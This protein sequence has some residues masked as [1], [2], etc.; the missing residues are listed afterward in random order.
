VPKR[1]YQEGTFRKE[2][3]HYYS[4]FYKDRPMPDGGTRS[5]KERFHLGKVGNLSELSARR[6]HNRL[7]QQINRERGSVPPAPRGETFKDAATRYMAELAPQLSCST[8]RQKNSH[9]NCHLLPR[10]GT[11]ALMVIDHSAAQQF[12]TEL[13]QT[14]KAKT[15]ENILGTLFGILDYARKCGL[16]TPEVTL[17]A[18]TIA[19]DQ[20]TYE[21]PYFKLATIGKILAELREPYRMIF[22]LD[23]ESG[24]RAGELLGLTVADL[25]LEAR[26]VHPRRQADDRTRVLRSLKTRKSAS[27]VPI[28][29]EMAVRLMAYLKNHWRPNPANLLFPNR[30]GRPLKRAYVVK[31]GL[32]P[33]LVKLGLPTY[34]VAFHAFRHSLGTVLANNKVSLKTVQEILRHTDSKTTVRY[35]IHSDMDERRT[36]LEAAKIGAIAAIG[37]NVPIGTGAGT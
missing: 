18:L 5:V 1:R 28:T 10:F 6:E 3:D 13:R 37:T 11:A 9:L 25:D 12:A 23:F 30:K 14:L 17:A 35:Y 29:P 22:A 32:K 26:I 34:R 24:L 21:A 2:N 19:P 33:A 7:R 16:R 20:D 8:I 15:I 27:P 31:W 36:A 4:F